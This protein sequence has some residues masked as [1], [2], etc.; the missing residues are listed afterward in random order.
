VTARIAPGWRDLAAC[1]GMDLDVFFRF[2]G[3]R[4]YE[5]ARRV[6]LA[7]PVVRECGEEAMRM[8]S[9]GEYL[10]WRFGVYGGMSPQERRAR[11]I[12]L[13]RPE[14]EGVFAGRRFRWWDRAG[15]EA[16]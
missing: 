3:Q 15:E 10:P 12:R 8:E 7:C 5:E 13:R 6:C 14:P 1:K 2:K 9:S 16:S 11:V 4:G